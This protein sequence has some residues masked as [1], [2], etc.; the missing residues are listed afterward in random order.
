[1]LNSFGSELLI[2]VALKNIIVKLSQIEP[3]EYFSDVLSIFFNTEE[4]LKRKYAKKPEN[5]YE[6]LRYDLYQDLLQQLR[7]LQLT[8]QHKTDIIKILHDESI[9]QAAQ[10]AP[11]EPNPTFTPVQTQWTPCR[12]ISLLSIGE[13]IHYLNC[14]EP[15]KCLRDV[16]A[17]FF[18]T[19]TFLDEE[20]KNPSNSLNEQR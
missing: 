2:T 15:D 13:M 12:P 10:S 18:D 7:E 1:M 4:I 17:I 3:W 11:L 20:Y 16:L 5:V 19:A 9:H 8:A 14:L 6:Q